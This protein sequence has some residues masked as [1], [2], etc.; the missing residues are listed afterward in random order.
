MRPLGLGG[1]FTAYLGALLAIGLLDAAWLL[2]IA[3]GFY[4]REIGEL[5]RPTPSL[6]PTALFYFG[7]PAGLLALAWGPQVDSAFTALWRGALV[8]LVAYGTYD[9]TN[10]A[11]LR[12]WSV[13][14]SLVDGVWGMC[15][16]AAGMLTAWW[17][18][19]RFGHHV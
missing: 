9:L 7:Y 8:G 15:V 4:Q 13:Q 1:W 5:M 10:W 6:L 19:Q 14:V 3:R 12:G 16:S 2:G 18:V 11:T 17:A